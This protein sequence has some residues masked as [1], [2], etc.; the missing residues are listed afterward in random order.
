ME[1]IKV[2]DRM[3]EEKEYFVGGNN[4]I[5]TLWLD[6]SRFTRIAFGDKIRDL[7]NQCSEQGDDGHNQCN[8]ANVFFSEI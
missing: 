2:T 3:P 4:Y 1:W 7:R 8:R 5:A 6:S